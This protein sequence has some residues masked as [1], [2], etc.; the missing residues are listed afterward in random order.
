MVASYYGFEL[1]VTPQAAI[2]EEGRPKKGIST[3]T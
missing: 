3:P 1:A 2:E